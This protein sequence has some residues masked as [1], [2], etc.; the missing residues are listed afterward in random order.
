MRFGQ[1]HCYVDTQQ[2]LQLLK[3]ATQMM[4][5]SPMSTLLATTIQVQLGQNLTLIIITKVA[6]HS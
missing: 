6:E 4:P 3:H 5:M 1:C 2:K